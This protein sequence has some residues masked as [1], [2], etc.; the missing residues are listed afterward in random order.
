MLVAAITLAGCGSASGLDAEGSMGRPSTQ[1][2]WTSCAAEAPDP[3]GTGGVDALAL[4]RLGD[5][6]TPTAGIV[7]REEVQRRADGGADRVATESRADEV[8][9]L[10]ALLR[11]PGEP[12]TDGPCTADLRTV[13]WFVLLDDQGRWIRPG[14]PKDSCGQ[15]R[16]DVPA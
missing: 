9:A 5:G 11:L 7:C 10:V 1:P 3:P 8:A 14:V 2:R 4:P 15:V 16:R 6:F 12:P 13:P